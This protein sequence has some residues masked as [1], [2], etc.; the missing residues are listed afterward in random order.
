MPSLYSE[1]NRLLWAGMFLIT[2]A[3]CLRT[4]LWE[5]GRAKPLGRLHWKMLIAS[6]LMFSFA[7]LDIAFGLRHNIEAFIYFKGGALQEFEDVSNW[8]NVMKMVCYVGQ[9]FVGDA[10]LVC[11]IQCCEISFFT[12][13]VILS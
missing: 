5:D 10:I 2:S 4:L 12:S 1:T 13:V 6:L 9:T 7:T 11:D 8:V 3:H